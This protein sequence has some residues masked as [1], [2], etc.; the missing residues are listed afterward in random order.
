MMSKIATGGVDDAARLRSIAT[1]TDANTH[2][3]LEQSAPARCARALDVGAGTGSIA[4][5]MALHWPHTAVTALDQDVTLMATGEPMP[6]NAAV[7]ERDIRDLVPDQAFDLIHARFVLAHLPDRDEVAAQVVEMLAPGG[8]LV[9]T[10]PYALAPASRYP[11]VEAVMAAYGAYCATSGMDLTWSKSVPGLLQEHGLSVVTV[12][13]A[14]GRLG[15]G[16][17]LDRWAPLIERVCDDLISGGLA[18][19]VVDEFMQLCGSAQVYD[20]PQVM[21]TTVAQRGR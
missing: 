11:A 9:I 8:V 7:V 20:V 5:W 18:A 2:R 16:P 19:G 1:S 17:G 10:E 13:S 3:V 15:G 14:A 12:E 4:R 6:T 21:L